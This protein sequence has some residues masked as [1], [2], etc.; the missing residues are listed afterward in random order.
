[1]NIIIPMA[2]AGKRLRPHTLLTPKPL[3]KI[4][5]KSIVHRLVE[6]L[7]AQLNK[8]IDE[9][10]FVVGD[11]DK[12]SSNE[13]LELTASMGIKGSIY[14]Q[15]EPLGT[16][17]AVWCA[18]KLLKK[19]VLIAFADTLF[20]SDISPDNSGN[21]LIWVK[22]VDDPRQFGVVKE[23][24]NGNIIDFIEKPD[25]FD[26]RLAIIGIYYFSDGDGLFNEIEQ[27]IKNNEK[28]S[29]EFQLTTVLEKLKD[30]GSTFKALPV[31][32]WMDFGNKD[33]CVESLK[34]IL[35]EAACMPKNISGNSHII[36][37]SYIGKGVV[38]DNSTI[39]PFASVEDNCR[40]SQT[41][42][43]NSIIQNNTIIF[44]CLINNSMVGT[45]CS[46][47]GINKEI[48]IGD[49]SIIK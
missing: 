8:P 13:L 31:N 35:T 14:R 46:I 34:E 32:K 20:S 44:D 29:N 40:I 45:N 33:A 47:S 15:E 5:G 25:S 1:M 36:E 24:G 28:K 10:G 30:K 11:I 41:T 37:P 19:E 12:E 4:A 43:S 42:V 48:S 21:N 22:E 17:H 18:N 27:L 39:G 7:K 2:G 26:Q 3:I 49:Y 16:A 23:D 6:K 9:I 38:I